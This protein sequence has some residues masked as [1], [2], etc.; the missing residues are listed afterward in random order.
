ME[1]LLE[2]YK[3][4]VLRNQGY[5]REIDTWTELYNTYRADKILIYIDD[6][7]NYIKKN[8]KSIL[9][10]IKL[11]D[12]IE[13][14]RVKEVI[15]LRYIENMTYEDIAFK[16]HFSDKTIYRLHSKGMNVIGGDLDVHR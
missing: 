11:I 4:L 14:D 1:K 13:D 12:E 7:E 8:K 15:Y 3:W 16:L 9:H 6:L 2:N 10:I 5:K